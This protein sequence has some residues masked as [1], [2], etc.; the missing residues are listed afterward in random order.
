M[1]KFV[2]AVI[3]YHVS[4]KIKMA[5]EMMMMMMMMMITIII[6][7]IIQGQMYE[8][9]FLKTRDPRIDNDTLWP[10]ADWIGGFHCN[11]EKF[12]IFLLRIVMIMIIT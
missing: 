11:F 5:V 6:I 7:I 2:A 9:P 4:S 1:F 8:L 12:C 3:N 10:S